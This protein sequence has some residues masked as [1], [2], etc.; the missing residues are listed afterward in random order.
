MANAKEEDIRVIL[1]PDASWP[2]GIKKEFQSNLG[3]GDQLT[4]KNN[5]HPGFIVNFN[6]EDA[7]NTGYLFPSDIKKAMWVKKLTG[8]PGEVKCAKQ[9]EYW[10]GFKATGVSPDFKT[11]TVSNPNDKEQIFVFTLRFT[12]NPQSGNCIDWD[13]GGTDRNGPSSNLAKTLLIVG[14]VVIAGIATTKLIGLW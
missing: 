13:P 8:A 4:F 1:T 6:I 5:Y 9:S 11:L 7:Q 14:L 12:K 10:D 3:N 2:D